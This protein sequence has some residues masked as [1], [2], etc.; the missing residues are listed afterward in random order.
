MFSMTIT[1][2]SI[3]I[4][5]IIDYSAPLSLPPAPPAASPRPLGRPDL[6]EQ[7]FR[8][9]N[10]IARLLKGK[11]IPRLKGDRIFRENS[12]PGHARILWLGEAT[13][14]LHAPQSAS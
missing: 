6:P 5:N 10:K 12:V 3:V 11:P 2:T 13:G 9:V 14:E 8:R 4:N 7:L 1:I